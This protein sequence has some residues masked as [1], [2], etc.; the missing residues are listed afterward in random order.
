MMTVTR[1]FLFSLLLMPMLASAQPARAPV[2]SAAAQ[3]FMQLET[4]DWIFK[5]EAL[6]Y[7]SRY[8]V[9]NAGPAVQ[10]I[11][12]DK[13]PNN[14]WL[15]G[16][17]VIAMAR[18]APDK[19]AALAKAHAADPHVEIRV[20]VAQVCADLPKDQATPILEKLLEDKTPSIQFGA[21][22][23]YA[24]HHG[25]KAWTRAE[26][27]TAK[28]PDNQIAPAARALAW[29]GSEPALARLHELVA[30]GKHQHE[31]LAGLKGVT[32]PA[33]APIYLDLIASSS[34]STLLAGAW[35]A[36]Q[37]FQREAVISACQAALASGDEKKVQAVASLV[38]G[39]LKEPAMGE[40]LLTVLAETKD[41][42]TLLLGLSALS[43]V[44]ADRF[45]AYFLTQLAHDDPQV[46]A[47]AASCLAQ[48]KEVNLY[49]T[50]EKTLADTDKQVRVAVL[51]ALQNAAG[52][53]VPQDR[54]LEYFTPSLLSPGPETRAAA[55]AVIAPHIT[56]DNGE[57]VLAVLQ[58]MQNE[59]GAGGT[60]PLMQAI[61]RMV[62]EEKSA[63]V[64]E[65][66]GYLTRWH[67][68]G[69]F[70]SG[71]AVPGADVNGLTIAYPPEQEVDLTKRYNVKY[72]I[73]TDT[74]S[75]KK[76]NEIEIGW[77]PATVGNAD[78]A[79]FL[80]KPDRSQLQIPIGYGVCYAYTEIILPDKK[81]ARL[82]FLFKA[83]AQDRVWLNG[84]VLSLESKV[85]R[86]GAATKTA[87]VTLGAGKN[88][89]LVKVATNDLR[90]RS[91][92]LSLA[93]LEGK[94]V[95]WSYK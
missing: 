6:D 33:L 5:A 73:M 52:E 80:A 19:A 50:L 10:K 91:F 21:L 45:T 51:R 68:I 8:D 48:C 28:T 78:G 62:P 31:I 26:P 79:L 13:S 29:I 60:N 23:A 20:A 86:Q 16:Q 56:Q 38:A 75:A 11:L 42:T 24:R 94:P 89:L 18:I 22:A 69:A 2:P 53:H 3:M 17:A 74:R 43:C 4:V 15:R 49:E 47:S 46:R 66:C 95:K 59:Y 44:E 93:D 90:T 37:T 85:N 65:A 34:D 36:L 58:K 30:Q 82:K 40:A 9:P 77:V 84:K 57:A 76:I 14:R 35:E 67:V 87:T 7:L 71:Y 88:R 27:I 32:N 72:N 12:D 92:A 63:V 54:I 41:R 25:A 70:P 55:I 64:L 1:H 83:K 81:E 39:Y 61:F